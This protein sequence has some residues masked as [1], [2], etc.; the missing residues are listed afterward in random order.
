[1]MCAPC[2]A[3]AE[4]ASVRRKSSTAGWGIFAATGLFFAWLVF[5]YLGMGLARA[6]STFFGGTP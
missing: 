6:P 3:Q 2:V 1:M 4:T 5:Y